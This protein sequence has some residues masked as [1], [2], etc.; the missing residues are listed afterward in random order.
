MFIKNLQHF[1]KD[2]ACLTKVT[3]ANGQ[4]YLRICTGLAGCCGETQNN[5]IRPNTANA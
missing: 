2:V 5:K 1:P 4:Q 3:G